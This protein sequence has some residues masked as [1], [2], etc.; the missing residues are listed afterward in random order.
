MVELNDVAESDWDG[1]TPLPA[2]LAIL[3]DKGDLPVK[4]SELRQLARVFI[5]HKKFVKALGNISRMHQAYAR[6]SSGEAT[7]LMLRGQP[8]SGKTHLLKFYALKFPPIR[9]ENGWKRAVAFV[10]APARGGTNGLMRAILHELGVQVIGRRNGS[11]LEADVERHL[12]AQGVELLI[13][14]EFQHVVD[15][16]TDDY[17]YA[18]ADVLK[19]FL[20]M[21]TCQFVFSGL[22]VSIEVFALNK[23]FAGRKGDEV[24]LKPYDWLSEHDQVN[25]LDYLAALSD[26]MVELGMFSVHPPLAGHELGQRIHYATDGLVGL[27]S[28]LVRCAADIAMR[29]EAATIT[30]EHL[31]QAFEMLKRVG[32]TVNPFSGTCPVPIENRAESLL[33]I[34][35]ELTNLSKRKSRSPRASFSR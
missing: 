32:V 19:N 13:L 6:H 29:A 24:E 34:G 12:K 4:A 21:N 5:L 1:P 22:D 25:Y 14:D 15:R 26:K 17:S 27:T 28:R 9:R 18:A 33:T 35:S 31:W 16:K 30:S 11:E 20:S 8:R 10:R 23:Q 7:F 3:L 2:D